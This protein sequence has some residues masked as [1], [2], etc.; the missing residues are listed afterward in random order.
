ML[1]LCVIEGKDLNSPLYLWISDC[2]TT[3]VQKSCPYPLLIIL[4]PLLK[5]S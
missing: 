2:L 1:I 4:T 3:T 5:I